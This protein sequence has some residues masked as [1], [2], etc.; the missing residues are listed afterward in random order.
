MEEHFYLV[1]KDV[2]IDD[3]LY[4]KGTVVGSSTKKT[5]EKL[6]AS[7]ATKNMSASSAKSKDSNTP[8]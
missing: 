8:S 3:V 7:K 4:R 2:I 5:V 1:E 6:T